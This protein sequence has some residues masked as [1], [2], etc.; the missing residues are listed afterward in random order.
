MANFK[1]K[2]RKDLG[3]IESDVRDH[4][5]R[6]QSARNLHNM[7]ITLKT[8]Q[9]LDSTPYRTK[10]ETGLSSGLFSTISA[11][12][13]KEKFAIPK[14]T[15]SVKSITS[16]QRP[17]VD[18]DSL[19]DKKQSIN[20]LELDQDEISSHLK[21]LKEEF[22]Q[23]NSISR[24][25]HLRDRKIEHLEKRIIQISENKSAIRDKLKRHMEIYSDFLAWISN[26]RIN[27]ITSDQII[28][29]IRS[30]A[31]TSP[32]PSEQVKIAK[33]SRSKSFE[34]KRF[35]SPYNSLPYQIPTQT[36]RSVASL[37]M[38]QSKSPTGED[39]WVRELWNL[40]GRFKNLLEYKPK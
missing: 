7:S 14:S 28:H 34:R 30:L 23:T 27:S 33:L 25:D 26:K 40:L 8:S 29:K 17:S 9:I 31:S 37:I 38:S 36:R 1:Q 18:V 11:S 13:F 5:Y 35:K 32:M 15:R 19:F 6:P 3:Q 4:G 39:E 10:E 12:H 22:G 2:L 16:K 20:K 24:A 21:E